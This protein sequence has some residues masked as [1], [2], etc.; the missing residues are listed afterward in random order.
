MMSWSMRCGAEDD[1]RE[2]VIRELT[3][4]ISSRSHS[5]NKGLSQSLMRESA[6]ENLEP[7]RSKILSH[8]MCSFCLLKHSTSYD[9]H[10]SLSLERCLLQTFM[11]TPSLVST[12]NLP[13]RPIMTAH[14]P[15]RHPTAFQYQPSNNPNPKSKQEHYEL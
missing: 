12:P 4:H 15:Y 1:D 5:V 14:D 11:T 8:F 2:M 6:P 9:N 3:S 7:Q 10:N 13:I